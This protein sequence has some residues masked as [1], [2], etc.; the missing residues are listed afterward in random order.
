MM[1][2]R[3]K[4][5]TTG[6]ADFDPDALFDSWSTTKTLPEDH[7][8]R[9]SIIAS[10]NLPS[11]DHYVYHAIASVTLDDVQQAIAGGSQHGLHAWYVDDDGETVD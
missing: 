11:N 4:A 10:F 2:S 1:A 3:R 8:L 7:D 6:S 9:S 5:R